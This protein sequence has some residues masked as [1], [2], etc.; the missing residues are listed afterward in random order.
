MN[1]RPSAERLDLLANLSHEARNALN[2]ML[3]HAQILA[4]EDLTTDQHAMLQHIRDAGRSLLY[5]LNDILDFSKMESGQL[6][7]QVQDFDVKE[8]LIR[9]E[10]F[11]GP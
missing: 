3:G 6:A 10:S 1:P 7:V 2:V 9:I 4:R 5:L 11:L 8:V